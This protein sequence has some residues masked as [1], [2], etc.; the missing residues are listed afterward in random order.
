MTDEYRLLQE[1]LYTSSQELNPELRG[2]EQYK[3]IHKNILENLRKYPRKETT[4]DELVK[5]IYSFLMSTRDDTSDDGL[6]ARAIH[7]LQTQEL[8]TAF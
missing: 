6:I 7:L 8:C 4:E 5:A 1:T 2:Q 3:Q